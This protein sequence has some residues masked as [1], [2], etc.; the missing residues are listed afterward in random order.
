MAVVERIEALRAKHDRLQVE[1]DREAHRPKPDDVQVTALK[2]E[3]LRI[4]DEIERMSVRH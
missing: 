3:K 2:R 4:K 1:I